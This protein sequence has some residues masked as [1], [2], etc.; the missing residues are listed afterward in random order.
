MLQNMCSYVR[1]ELLCSLCHG[2]PAFCSWGWREEGGI[3]L[4]GGDLVS[5]CDWYSLCAIL[6]NRRRAPPHACPAALPAPLRLQV[7][8]GVLLC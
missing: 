5:L 2:D 1:L 4:P 8:T 3:A 6:H 7:E